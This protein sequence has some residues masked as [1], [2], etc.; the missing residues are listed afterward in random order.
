[1]ASCSEVNLLSSSTLGDIQYPG[2]FNFG[3][4]AEAMGLSTFLMEERVCCSIGPRFAIG[5]WITSVTGVVAVLF[6]G[7]L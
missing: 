1:M 3:I 7:V 4:S 6:W 2:L 5:F